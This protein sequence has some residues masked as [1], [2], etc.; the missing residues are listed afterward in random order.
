LALEALHKN[1]VIYRDLKPEN[2]VLDENGHVMITD[3]GLSKKG[4]I[5]KINSSFCGTPAYL[6]PEILD[7]KGHN[8]MADWY[9]MGV[10]L[11]E[12]LVGTPPFYATSRE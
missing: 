8:R 9:E 4:E 2:L 11:Y 5:D 10:V 6:A 12:F 3:F 7:K 1:M